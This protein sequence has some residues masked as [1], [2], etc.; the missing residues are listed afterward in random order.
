MRRSEPK[1]TDLSL[2]LADRIE[3]L[4][5][6]AVE[7]IIRRTYAGRNMLDGG[8]WSWY[9]RVD[10]KHAGERAYVGSM[11]TATA[12]GRAKKLSVCEDDGIDIHIIAGD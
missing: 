5:G 10:P 4:T 12:C 3:K 1:I 6:F 2:K 11:D 8:S 9:M 7:P